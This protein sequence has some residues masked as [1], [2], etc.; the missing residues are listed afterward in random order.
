MP[1]ETTNVINWTKQMCKIGYQFD[2]EFDG[3]GT[4]PDQE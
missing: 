1:M 2:C 3:W 4:N